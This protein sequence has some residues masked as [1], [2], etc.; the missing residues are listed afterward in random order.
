M[1][2]CPKC[3]AMLKAKAVEGKNILGCSCG[4]I[5]DKDTEFLM[6]HKSVSAIDIEVVHNEEPKPHDITDEECPKCHNKKAY[7][8]SKNVEASDEPDVIIFRCTKC[9]F[10]WREGRW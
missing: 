7:F 10:G 6:K 3:G 9:N 2:F 1:R 8:W 4:Y 5:D